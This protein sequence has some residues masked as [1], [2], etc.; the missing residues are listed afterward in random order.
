MQTC[1]YC[2][3]VTGTDTISCEVCESRYHR[4]CWEESGRCAVPGCG[5]AT[6]SPHQATERL[7]AVPPSIPSGAATAGQTEARPPPT[8]P[9][10]RPPPPPPG[11][12]A[13][14][15]PVASEVPAGRGSRWLIV[16][17]LVVLTIV[18]GVAVLTSAS[19]RGQEAAQDSPAAVPD[20]DE[21]R[22]EDES[23]AESPEEV[24]PAA[25][26]DDQVLDAL[27]RLC[28][29]DDWA[30]CD[31]LGERAPAGSEY[32]QFALTCGE[33]SAPTGACADQFD[34]PAVEAGGNRDIE[35][36][37]GESAPGSRLV[38]TDI[39]S[40]EIAGLVSS[41][42]IYVSG[43][44]QG[45]YSSAWNILS[46]AAKGRTSLDEFESGNATSSVSRFVIMSADPAGEGVVEV[47]ARFRSR[48]APADG[49]DGETCTDWEMRY[50]MVF[51]SG[52]WRI[53]S[54]EG[55][56][57]EGHQGC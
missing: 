43:I 21:A 55:A 6:T 45:D 50:M 38:M 52:R 23:T 46:P 41:F 56:F 18:A 14:V 32:E 2:H 13:T 57:G 53:D 31:R 27:W 11:S 28:Q 30:S 37:E 25:Y 33:R 49:P 54:A 36:E 40:D 51:I 44:N 10:P 24:A 47:V 34:E 20:D 35:A 12:A 29:E 9:P 42:Q 39:N 5:A 16:A 1:P 15:P 8:A 3:T 48:Q 26:G 19:D 17:V 4:D 7:T 22:E